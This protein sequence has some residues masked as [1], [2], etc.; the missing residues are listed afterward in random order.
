MG[1]VCVWVID[2]LFIAR[3][4]VCVLLDSF[5]PYNCTTYVRCA[6][7]VTPCDVLLQIMRARA[8]ECDGFYWKRNAIKEMSRGRKIDMFSHTLFISFH[9]IYFVLS[10][11]NEQQQQ[12]QQQRIYTCTSGDVLHAYVY[13]QH[14]V[15][16]S[17]SRSLPLA[18]SPT[19]PRSSVARCVGSG[20]ALRCENACI[21][22][23]FFSA[24]VHVEL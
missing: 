8:R 1:T 13:N 19:F 14:S 6:V 4:F 15:F 3:W 24:I 10:I 17:L 23:F 2:R 21:Y 11:F 18:L 12:Q 5:H 16:F 20:A 9:F 22:V 7:A